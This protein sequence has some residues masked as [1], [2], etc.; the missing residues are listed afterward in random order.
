MNLGLLVHAFE[1]F[2]RN[3][4][5]VFCKIL[6]GFIG[7]SEVLHNKARYFGKNPLYG[8]MSKG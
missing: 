7:L 1:R 5:L 4:P 8:K 3:G 6:H 2:L